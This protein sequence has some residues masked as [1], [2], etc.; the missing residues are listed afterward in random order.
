MCKK[1]S[2]FLWQELLYRKDQVGYAKTGNREE[3]I[4]R[5]GLMPH[6]MFWNAFL[7][8]KIFVTSNLNK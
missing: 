2:A 1:S 4:I 6:V 3:N 5:G 7:I 8:L